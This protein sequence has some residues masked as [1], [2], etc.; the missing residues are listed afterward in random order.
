MMR[1][2]ETEDQELDEEGAYRIGAK[3]AWNQSYSLEENDFA[4]KLPLRRDMVALI[5]YLRDTRVTGTSSTGNFPLKAVAEIG[6]RFV[7]PITLE[8]KIGDLVFKVRSESEVWPFYFRHV[9]AA[10]PGLIS[11]GPGRR[12]KV[13]PGGENFL[14]LPPVMQVFNLTTSWWTQINWA[15]AFPYEIRSDDLGPDFRMTV[16]DRLLDLPQDK[17][18]DF[19]TFADQVIRDTRL[20]WPIEDQE[21]ARII[22]R[23]IIENIVV[24]PH[25]DFGILQATYQPNEI[26]GGRHQRISSISITSFGKNLLKSLK[27][28]AF[29]E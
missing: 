26:L 9:L 20:I 1:H 13:L 19:I 4:E 3:M 7:K 6:A 14:A 23:S 22:L 24:K 10:A 29:S 18:T 2:W 28:I 21:R 27:S 17:N 5:T 11:G 25:I 15:I 8:R 12:W 16:L